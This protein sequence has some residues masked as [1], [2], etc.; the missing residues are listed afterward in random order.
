M[1]NLKAPG[2]RMIRMNNGVIGPRSPRRKT[3]VV[4][5][6]A[7]YP[8][9]SK[10]HLEVAQIY[11]DEKMAGGVP[12]CDEL[13]ALVLHLFTEEEALVMRHLTPKAHQTA[14][15]LAA[16]E[17]RSLEA[18]NA[19]LNSLAVEKHIIL[20]LGEGDAKIYLAVPLL[21]GVFEFVLAR[22]SMDSLTDWHRRFCE[23]F[24][25]LYETGYIIDNKIKKPPVIKYLPIGKVIRSN[26]AAYPSDKLEE[27][28]SRYKS[29]GLTMC[30]CRMTEKVVGRGCDKPMDVCMTLG[31]VAD[32]SIKAGRSRRITMKDALE[33][34]AEAEANGLVT[35]IDA[36]DPNIG[37]TS[38][39]CCGDCCHFMRRITEFNV[40]AS[41]APPH[42]TPH[43]DLKK[44]NYCG[45]C[46]LACPMAAVTVDMVNKT[47]RV[48]A[49]RCIGCAQCVAACSKHKAIEMV[50]VADC[51]E[52]LQTGTGI[53][54]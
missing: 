41:L 9:V 45:K 26:T 23:L 12:I 47:H 5:T 43:I 32:M 49:C 50:A 34:K 38:C 30:Q 19:V 35:W 44:C 11:A 17:H 21:P 54:F 25:Q 20:G 14:Q 1:T 18:I 48:D 24:E 13:I 28:F 2:H 42:F 51:E 27:V 16:A 10:A 33:I 31:P 40:P 8:K 39:S 29:F 15:S 52:F 53:F 37:G 7:D 4:K 6:A 22:R 3:V 36:S 46:A